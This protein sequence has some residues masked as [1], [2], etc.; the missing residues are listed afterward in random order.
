MDIAQGVVRATRPTILVVE[1]DSGVRRSLQML[2][3]ARG[4]E[5][6][7]YF[8]GRPL[9]DDPRIPD[10]AC[11]IADYRL[12]DMDGLAVLTMLRSRGW[13]GPAILITAYAS[14]TLAYLAEKAGFDTLMEKPLQPSALI[15]TVSRLV[16]CG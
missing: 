14:S 4:Y 11:L 1:D 10:A 5:V 6:K 8:E 13:N 15:S 16:A 3:R 2:L 7:A 12:G 9:L